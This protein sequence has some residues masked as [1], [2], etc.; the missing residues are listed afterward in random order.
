MVWEWQ[1]PF[2]LGQRFTLTLPHRSKFPPKYY[3]WFFETVPGRKWSCVWDLSTPTA[4]LLLFHPFLN[5]HWSVIA[6]GPF[7][8]SGSLCRYT[9]LKPCRSRV[10]T[11]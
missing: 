11:Q 2:Y 8:D 10:E 6:I 1:T 9:I 4:Y 5:T 3:W 7:S